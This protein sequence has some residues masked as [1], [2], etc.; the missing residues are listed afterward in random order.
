MLQEKTQENYSMLGEEQI[1]KFSEIECE[2]SFLS[3]RVEVLEEKVNKA[4]EEET[5]D[6]PEENKKRKRDSNPTKKKRCKRIDRLDKSLH[7]KQ[8]L[9]YLRTQLITV[10][11]CKIITN[12]LTTLI[13]VFHLI[14]KK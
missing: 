2:N 10:E 7:E 5:I 8:I 14:L 6:L 9:D 13:Q 12:Q 3:F 4:L 1:R 11:E